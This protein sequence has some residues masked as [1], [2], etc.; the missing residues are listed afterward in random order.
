M[1][2]NGRL[3]IYYGAADS[4]IALKSMALNDLLSELK[5]YPKPLEPMVIQHPRKS[6]IVSVSTFPPRECGIATFTRD[7]SATFNQLF[8]PGVESKVVA[9]NIDDVTRLPYSKKSLPTSVS[10]VERTML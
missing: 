2:K 7:L 3:Y 9:L 10:P 5:R 8:A 6:W 4:R 1:I